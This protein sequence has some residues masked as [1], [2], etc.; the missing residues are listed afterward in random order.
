MNTVNTL[1][2]ELALAKTRLA[3]AREAV[4]LEKRLVAEA[5][6]ALK[7]ERTFVKTVN[8]D[9][10]AAKTATRLAKKA[11][12]IAVLEA[13]LNALKNPVGIKA[14]KAAKKPS[15]VRTYNRAAAEATLMAA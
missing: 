13:K 12:R 9:A 7:M 15:P 3:A 10:K 2:Q 6:A 8:A 14:K 5:A 4:T 1:K 11:E